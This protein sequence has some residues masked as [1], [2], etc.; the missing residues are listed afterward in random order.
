MND[1]CDE[2][3]SYLS[4]WERWNWF[5]CIFRLFFLIRPL[6]DAS[7][8]RNSIFFRPFAPFRMKNY[9]KAAIKL[10]NKLHHFLHVCIHLAL[11]WFRHRI[12]ILSLNAEKRETRTVKLL[13]KYA[14]KQSLLSD[15]CIF[16]S[17]AAG[18]FN[19][20]RQIKIKLRMLFSN[21]LNYI[22]RWYAKKGDS[23]L[24]SLE[25]RQFIIY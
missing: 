5:L 17:S 24:A 12:Q 25:C 1:G 11:F 10:R 9:L 22:F 2:R 14:N 21:R 8:R 4:I 23:A 18:I 3:Q 19:F 20:M 13:Q 16:S 7:A 15:F 6:V